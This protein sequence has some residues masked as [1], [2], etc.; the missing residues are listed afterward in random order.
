MA[1]RDIQQRR[2]RSRPRSGGRGLAV[3]RD[4][5]D[6]YSP[7]RMSIVRSACVARKVGQPCC[8]TVVS[9]LP[10]WTVRLALLHQDPSVDAPPQVQALQRLTQRDVGRLPGSFQHRCRSRV[11]STRSLRCRVLVQVWI[12]ERVRVYRSTFVSPYRGLP[13][14]QQYE[15]ATVYNHVQVTVLVSKCTRTAA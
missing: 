6:R 8:D 9:F 4:A 15:F 14:I 7:M 2:R 5:C 3:A 11:R 10:V 12:S 13:R 1:S